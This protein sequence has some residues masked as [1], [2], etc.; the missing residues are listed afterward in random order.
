MEP[1][2]PKKNVGAQIWAKRGQN[3]S[4]TCKKIRKLLG[5][6]KAGQLLHSYGHTVWKI[7]NIKTETTATKHEK[8]KSR[9]GGKG[10]VNH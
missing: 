2:F 3:G 9:K 10:E 4:K 8:R 6:V 5:I 1:D 7:T